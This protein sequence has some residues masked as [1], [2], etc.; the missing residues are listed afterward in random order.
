M[1]S[2]PASLR[3]SFCI[4]ELSLHSGLFAYQAGAY[5]SVHKIKQ[6][7]K[8]FYSPL[9]AMLVDLRVTPGSKFAGMPFICLGEERHCQSKTSCLKTQ[10]ALPRPRA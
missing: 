2:K 10:V 3:K 7:L 4:T 9:D 5:S 6:L 8:Y 1:A